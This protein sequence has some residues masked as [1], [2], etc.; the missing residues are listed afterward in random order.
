MNKLNKIGVSA[1]CGS[2]AAFSAANAGELTVSGGADMTWMSQN[3]AVTGNPLGIGSDF[4]LAGSGELDNGWSVALAITMTNANSYSNTSVTVGVPGIGDILFNQGGS[5]TGIQRLDDVTPTVWEEADGAGLS[6]TINKITGGSAGA[7]IEIKPESVPDG[8]TARFAYTA[9]A[10]G[11]SSTSDKGTGGD[12][13]VAGAGWDLTLEAS[14]ALHGVAGLTVYA[15]M[16]NVDQYAN[17]TATTGDREEYVWGAKYAIG[18]FTVGY[19]KSNEETGVTGTTEYDN[20]AYGI[21]FN[22]N[23]N[24]SVGYGHVESD[25]SGQGLETPEANTF[26]AAYTMGGATFRIADISVD[27]QGYQ[28]AS[29]ADLD[30]RVVSLGLAF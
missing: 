7:T 12:S 4:G 30:S 11:S 18:G 13:G 6:A 9:D 27:N 16:A 17:G 24:L 10:D 15:G 5:G 23:D 3:D 14:D 2:L 26:S 25:E 22:V 19:Q 8:L 29:T 20:T 1:L 28:A 21:T